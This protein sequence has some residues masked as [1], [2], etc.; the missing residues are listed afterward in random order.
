MKTS[1]PRWRISLAF[2]ICLVCADGLSIPGGLTPSDYRYFALDATTDNQ[3]AASGRAI[4]APVPLAA[5]SSATSVDKS[6]LPTPPPARPVGAPRAV[7]PAVPTGDAAVPKLSLRTL[8]PAAPAADSSADTAETAPVEAPIDV[9]LKPPIIRGG[10]WTAPTYADSTIGDDLDGE[11]LDVRN[12]AVEALGKYNGAVVVTDPNTGRILTIVNQ[13][14]ALTSGFQPCSTIKISVALAGLSEGVIQPDVKG[15]LPGVHA[16][17]TRALARSNNRYFAALGERLG[18]EK[19]WQY[20]HLYGYGETAG[21]NIPGERPGN[22]PSAPPE[23]GGV[24]MLSSFGEEVTQTPL[25]LAA[26]VSAIANGGTL[27]YLQYPR[28]Q[29]QA[30]Y[31]VPRVKRQLGIGKLIPEITPG[32]LGAVQYGTARHAREE[33]DLIAGKTGTCS[34]ENHTHL[35]WFG[36]FN[37]V[38]NRRLVVVVLLTGGRP[39]AGSTAASVAGKFYRRLDAQNYFQVSSPAASALIATRICCKP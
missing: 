26:L 20:A 4:A 3:V 37:D 5:L 19:V 16:D 25:E 24:G 29:L 31:F 13:K 8:S 6:P 27:Y 23:N 7:A 21:L 2:V 12:A 22:F 34:D 28:N 35:G 14:L 33:D 18:F 11:D 9:K 32:M 36:S 30:Q 1:T 17:L 38:G 15:Q 39:A 10:P